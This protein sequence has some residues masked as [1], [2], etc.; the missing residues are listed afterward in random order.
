MGIMRAVCC[1]GIGTA[2][3]F[4]LLICAEH[5]HREMCLATECRG[6][7][8]IGTLQGVSKEYKRHQLMNN[9]HQNRHEEGDIS[10]DDFEYMF[11][12]EL[13]TNAKAVLIKR[14]QSTN[15]ALPESVPIA[16]VAMIMSAF[17]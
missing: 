17:V 9:E 15:A 12:C 7:I 1:I 14:Q 10:D 8:A 5:R 13:V 3:D 16:L 11:I 4:C 6:V 2:K